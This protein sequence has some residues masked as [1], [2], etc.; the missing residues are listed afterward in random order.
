M[1]PVWLQVSPGLWQTVQLRQYLVG[2]CFSWD[3][4]CL[5][6]LIP[7]YGLIFGFAS[8]SWHTAANHVAQAPTVTGTVVVI[9]DRAGGW[10]WQPDL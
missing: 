7:N 3:V 9:A 10:Q 1:V 6:S 2:V 5:L 4:G 8:D